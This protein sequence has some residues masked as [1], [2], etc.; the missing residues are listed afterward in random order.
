[1]DTFICYFNETAKGVTVAVDRQDHVAITN[2][3]GSGCCVTDAIAGALGL[4]CV[5]FGAPEDERDV[6]IATMRGKPIKLGLERRTI[7]SLG[8]L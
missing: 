3:E 4:G 8:F 2:G 1:M 6:C 5:Q 7:I